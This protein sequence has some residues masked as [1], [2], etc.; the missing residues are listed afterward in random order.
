M[1]VEVLRLNIDAN[2]YTLT[3]LTGGTKIAELSFTNPSST[4]TVEPVTETPTPEATETPT[5]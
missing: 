5:S 1:Q 2:P 4:P 3:L